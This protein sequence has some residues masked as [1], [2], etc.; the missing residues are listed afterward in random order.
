MN[1]D[2]GPGEIAE[3]ALRIDLSMESKMCGIQ[4]E[5]EGNLVSMHLADQTDSQK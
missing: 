1:G 2:H 3:M 4:W 5:N